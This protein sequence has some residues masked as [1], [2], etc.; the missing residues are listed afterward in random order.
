M[1]LPSVRVFLVL[2][3]NLSVSPN[4]Q[5]L[6]ETINKSLRHIKNHIQERRNGYSSAFPN[7]RTLSLNHQLRDFYEPSPSHNAML[8]PLG[9]LVATPGALRVLEECAVLPIR[10][11]ARHSR[12]DWG[13][14]P[15]EDVRSNTEAL[16]LGSRLLSSYTIANGLKI[17]LITEADRSTT[18]IL[19]P[20][21]Y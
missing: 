3:R 9:D 15:T 18:T 4:V 19:L 6:G 1:Q 11:I 14:V 17:W 21:E 2:R 10:L 13:D 7:E 8:F 12:G 5:Q 20:S 16:I